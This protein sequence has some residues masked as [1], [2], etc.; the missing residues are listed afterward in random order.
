MLFFALFWSQ[1]LN[2]FSFTLKKFYGHSAFPTNPVVRW[3][4]KKCAL[5]TGF[6]MRDL[7][8]NSVAV[9]IHHQEITLADVLG[10][11]FHDEPHYVQ[12]RPDS[13]YAFFAG[14]TMVL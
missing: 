1:G 2:I 13:Y 9:I 7:S 3:C 6:F 10:Y 12:N 4:R 8:R 11:F 14:I 5:F